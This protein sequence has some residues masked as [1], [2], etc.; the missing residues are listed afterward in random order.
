M[1]TLPDFAA[2]SRTAM[3]SGRGLQDHKVDM[4]QGRYFS[5]MQL[6]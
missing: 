3:L 1:F 4:R 2:L 5:A 6:L